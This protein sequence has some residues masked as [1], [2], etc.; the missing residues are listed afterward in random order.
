MID[1]ER[2]VWVR[3]GY[4]LEALSDRGAAVWTEPAAVRRALADFLGVFPSSHVQVDAGLLFRPFGAVDWPGLLSRS[5][6]WADLLA[7]LAL[8]VADAARGRAAWGIGL[9]APA[10][11]GDAS[12]RGAIKAGVLLGGFLQAFRESSARFVAVDADSDHR[13]GRAAAPILRNA[14]MYGWRRAVILD[15][16]DAR[17]PWAS[18]SDAALV[19][20]AP[21]AEL[22]P[23]WSR[24][25]RTGGGLGSDFWTGAGIGGT[26]PAKYLLYGEAPAG[27]S[28]RAVVEAGR[29][30]R[31]AG[32]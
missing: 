9:P 32:V 12:E 30:L 5:G 8:A 14:E 7:E 22:V 28:A 10:A 16:L 26:L 15:E 13:A 25:E 21:F 11:L 18:V 1:G 19:R 17:E 23:L 20:R 4:A 3:V 6:A 29:S 27:L 24:G 31:A 2:T